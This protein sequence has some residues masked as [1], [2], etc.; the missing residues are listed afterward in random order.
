[1][2][3]AMTASCRFAF[4]A[5]TLGVVEDAVVAPACDLVRTSDDPVTHF[6]R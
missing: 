4:H 5:K 1:M 2:P 3:Y 6:G